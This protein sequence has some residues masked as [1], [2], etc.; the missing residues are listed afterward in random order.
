MGDQW[1]RFRGELGRVCRYF[2][3]RWWM[4]LKGG[5]LGCRNRGIWFGWKLCEGERR[6][7]RSVRRLLS[8]CGVV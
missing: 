8:E 6:F 5:R 1:G 4:L 2:L 7:H 3:S